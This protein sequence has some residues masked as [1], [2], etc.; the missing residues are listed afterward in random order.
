MYKAF[1]KFGTEVKAGESIMSFRGEIWT[2]IAVY[3]RKL[4]VE[5][6]G[7]FKRLLYPSVF[8]LTIK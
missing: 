1:D 4:E 6:K 7:G 2:L 5:V 8:N 3:E